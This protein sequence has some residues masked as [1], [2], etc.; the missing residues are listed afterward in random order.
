MSKYCCNDSGGNLDAIPTP[1]R[2]L[3]GRQP[4]PPI[5]LNGMPAT[6]WSNNSSSCIW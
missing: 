1:F 2:W 6:A 5:S 4:Y 3:W